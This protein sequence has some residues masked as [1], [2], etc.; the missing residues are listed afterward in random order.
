MKKRVK[1]FF[2][3]SSDTSSDGFLTMR[4]S[5]GNTFFTIVVNE[6]LTYDRHKVL[7]NNILKQGRT[8]RVY[9]YS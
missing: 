2:A 7:V 9:V 6:I 1:S 4:F 5:E 8:A 3:N